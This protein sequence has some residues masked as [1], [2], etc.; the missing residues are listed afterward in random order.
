MTANHQPS[1]STGMLIAGKYTVVKLS[2]NEYVG[3]QLL[4]I[5]GCL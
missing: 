2:L 3:L 4:C 1:L 5:S